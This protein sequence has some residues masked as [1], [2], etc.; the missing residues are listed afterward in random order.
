MHK[1]HVRQVNQLNAR[2]IRVLAAATGKNLGDD[3]EVWRKWWA[4]EQGYTYEPPPPRPRQDLTLADSKPTYR[5]GSP[6]RLLRGRHAGPHTH[7][8]SADRAG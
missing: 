2:I 7:R 6:R 8:P 5:I 4:E 1:L 3:R